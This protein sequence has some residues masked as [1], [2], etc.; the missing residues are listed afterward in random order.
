MQQML[1]PEQYA[2]HINKIMNYSKMHGLQV[3]LDLHGAPGSQSGSQDAGCSVKW[4]NFYFNTPYNF[5]LAV[6]AITQ[7]AKICVQWGDTC[8]G[9]ELLNEPCCPNG[10][11]GGGHMERS[12]LKSYYQQASKAARAAGLPLSKPLVI[13]DWTSWLNLYWKYNDLGSYEEVGRI[14]Y[15][16]H[17]YLGKQTSSQGARNSYTGLFKQLINFGKT[18]FIGEW[19]LDNEASSTNLT[20]LA[21]W[22]VNQA[23]QFGI[24]SSIWNYDGP[25]EWGSVARS[26]WYNV[27]WQPAFSSGH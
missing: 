20:S 7:L 27:S 8:F 19:A 11:D 6:E 2:P 3:L 12:N 13:Q 4:G 21:N 15:D 5:Q 26:H 25:G 9:I 16:A 14:I 10:N 24:G 1:T 18:F 22:F 17:L 23:N